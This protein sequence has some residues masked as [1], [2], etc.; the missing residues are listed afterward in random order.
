M[1]NLKLVEIHGSGLSI[2]GLLPARIPCLQQVMAQAAMPLFFAC[3]ASVLTHLRNQMLLKPKDEAMLCCLTNWVM[4]GPCKLLRMMAASS[5]TFHTVLA[6][7]LFSW[8]WD[9][10]GWYD[11]HTILPSVQVSSPNRNVLRDTIA[12]Y[13]TF[14]G[15]P[16]H[17]W[18]Q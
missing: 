7:N 17:H 18:R 2:H 8:L 6:G 1:Q 13:F 16:V 5:Y 11:S 4:G 14:A 12:L 10:E 9:W 3:T 15:M